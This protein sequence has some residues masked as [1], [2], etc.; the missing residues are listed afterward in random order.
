MLI[1]EIQLITK[2]YLNEYPFSN[3]KVLTFI[4][5]ISGLFTSFVIS[6]IKEKKSG[7]I[8]E[9]ESLENILNTKIIDKIKIDELYNYFKESVVLKKIFSSKNKNAKF[10]FLDELNNLSKKDEFKSIIQKEKI[11]IIFNSEDILDSDKILLIIS[12]KS[13]K[14]K[15]IK[16]V[17]NK[18]EIDNLEISGIFLLE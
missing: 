4:G 15:E 18:I 11:N 12:L 2:P 6:I 1:L 5:L 8:Y 14:F 13:L 10:L 3:K 9:E 16:K 7:L 17:K